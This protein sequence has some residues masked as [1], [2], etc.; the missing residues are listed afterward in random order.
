M[1]NEISENEWDTEVR[2]RTLAGEDEAEIRAEVIRRY[3]DVCDPRPL[4]SA[5]LKGRYIS[6]STR[7]RIAAV[8]DPEPRINEPVPTIFGV[9]PS[10]GRLRKY[11]KPDEAAWIKYL[12]DCC[13]D[14]AEGRLPHP[15]FWQALSYGLR[16]GHPERFH[17]KAPELPIKIRPELPKFSIK[18]R[19]QFRAQDHRPA[20]PSLDIRYRAIR[21]FVAEAVKGGLSKE[22]ARQKVADDL[23]LSA[24]TVRRAVYGD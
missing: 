8:F 19:L 6:E 9:L 21:W 14:L 4:V 1:L 10:H 16:C 17:G 23:N 2:L 20:D 7:R 15:I 5:I 3:L 22:K 18:I 13:H 12:R 24:R 11:L